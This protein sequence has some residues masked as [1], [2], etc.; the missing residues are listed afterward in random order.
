MNLKLCDFCGDEMGQHERVAELT[1]HGPGHERE[2]GNPFAF[3]SARL[4]GASSLEMCEGCLTHLLPIT[5]RVRAEKAARAPTHPHQVPPK[6]S[7][8]WNGFAQLLYGDGRIRRDT[9]E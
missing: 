3:L 7:M 6:T 9:E 8:D 2:Q 5:A 4:S 1:I